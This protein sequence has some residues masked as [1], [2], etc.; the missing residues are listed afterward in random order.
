MTHTHAT[1]ILT[2]IIALNS[3]DTHDLTSHVAK[4]A[5]LSLKSN[6]DVDAN[7]MS[8]LSNLF[9]QLGGGVKSF[10]GVRPLTRG[11]SSSSGAAS[12]SNPLALQDK[13]QS[14]KLTPQEAREAE[15]LL[16]KAQLVFKKIEK[17]AER[18][19]AKV[20]PGDVIHT[21]LTLGGI[22]CCLLVRAC[23]VICLT[24]ASMCVAVY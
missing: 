11:A 10:V 12:S 22:C 7:T 13:G 5:R 21:V 18:I 2:L 17:D 1:K 9:D 6:A 4:P 16:V 8:S 14:S 24:C 19:L 20:E 3:Y 15:E 23:Y